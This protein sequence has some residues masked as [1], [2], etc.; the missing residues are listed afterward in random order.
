MTKLGRPHSRQEIKGGELDHVS[1]VW[2]QAAS[3]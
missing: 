3:A 2:R 1:L